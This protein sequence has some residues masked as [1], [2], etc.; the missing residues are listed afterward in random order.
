[1]SPIKKVALFGKGNVGSAT[2]EHLLKA[3][4]QVTVFGRSKHEVPPGAI[5]VQVDYSLD[6]L[7]EALKGHDAIVSTVGPA[8]VLAQ[9]T[10]IDAAIIAGVRRFIPSEFSSVNTDP[11]ARDIPTFQLF[12]EIQDYLKAKAE[13]GDIEFTIFATGPFLEYVFGSPLF[14]DLERRVVQLHDK[15]DVRI[16]ATSIAGIGKAIAGG[17]Q[18][19][20]QTK[21]RVIH[22]HETVISQLKLLDLVKKAFPEV[23]LSITSVNSFDALDAAT[24]KFVQDP[25]D[26]IVAFELI[27]AVMVSGKYYTEYLELDNELVGLPILSDEDLEKDWVPLMAKKK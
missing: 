10:I 9:K 14:I 3:G 26:L 18:K 4:F 22:V 1:M 8:A 19:P 2:L 20:D 16:S 15:G 11:K 17:L 21:N 25:T 23:E 27:K 6:T 24:A 13:T 7:S 12:I 5:S